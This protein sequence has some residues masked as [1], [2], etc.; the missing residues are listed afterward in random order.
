MEYVTEG[1][2]S[3]T[4]IECLS[5]YP[6]KEAEYLYPPL[7]WI[8]LKDHV[9]VTQDQFQS[10]WGQLKSIEKFEGS[11]APEKFERRSTSL[12]A[13]AKVETLATDIHTT[14][15]FRPDFCLCLSGRHFVRT[16]CVTGKW[17]KVIKFETLIRT[18]PNAL[19]LIGDQLLLVC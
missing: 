1:L 5:V 15:L 2:S 8:K 3:G 14:Y 9:R 12:F 13:A 16:C 10:T 17:C 18:G 4:S 11:S 19:H 7:C 6:T